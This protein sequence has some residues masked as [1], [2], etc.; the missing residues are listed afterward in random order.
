MPPLTCK[1][2]R[3][4]G[5]SRRHLYSS[6]YRQ[7]YRGVFVPADEPLTVAT[8]TN[9][10]RLIL[11]DGAYPGASFIPDT[12]DPRQAHFGDIVEIHVPGF[13]RDLYGQ[14]V[15]ISFTARLRAHQVFAD[16]AAAIAQIGEDVRQALAADAQLAAD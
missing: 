9:A 15:E 1:E 8:W 11:P 2:A 12:A 5:I 14:E 16:S 3:E 13:E 4:L 10:A 6:A 7:L